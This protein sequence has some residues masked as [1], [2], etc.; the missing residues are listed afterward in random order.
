MTSPGGGA[1]DEHHAVGVASSRSVARDRRRRH[2]RR[3]LRSDSGGGVATPAVTESRVPRI[4]QIL[5]DLVHQ[6]QSLRGATNAPETVLLEANRRRIA[7]WQ[8]ELAQ[9]PLPERR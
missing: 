8:G 1:G 9:A 2:A 7:Y 4:R 6:R 5:A 3:V